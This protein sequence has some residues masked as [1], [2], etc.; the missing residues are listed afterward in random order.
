VSQHNS[1]RDE[2]AAW[3]KEAGFRGVL[4]EQFVRELGK[5]VEGRG[6]VR[7]FLAA[8]ID[9]RLL[10]PRTGEPV[11]FDPTIFHP[12]ASSNVGTRA[13]DFPFHEERKHIRYRTRDEH[14]VRIHGFDLHALAFSTVGS[15]GEEGVRELSALQARAPRVPYGHL[16]PRLAARV[17]RWASRIVMDAAGVTAYQAD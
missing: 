13:E 7:K 3:A 1:V 17:V 5:F 6:G 12:Y 11:F 14:G 15:L 4:T 16:I 10:D 9:V 8:K 2:F